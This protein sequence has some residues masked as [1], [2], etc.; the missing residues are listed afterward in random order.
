MLMAVINLLA[1]ARRAPIMA[2]E[3]AN[4]NE[5]AAQFIAARI[6]PLPKETSI[7]LFLDKRDDTAEWFRYRLSYLVYPHRLDVVRQ[8]ETPPNQDCVV[9]IGYRHGAEALPESVP[10]RYSQSVYT[11]RATCPLLNTALSV[12]TPLWKLWLY[13]ALAAGVLV[14]GSILIFYHNSFQKPFIASLRRVCNEPFPHL[15]PNL[16]LMHLYGSSL[17]LCAGLPNVA[18]VFKVGLYLLFLGLFTVVLS[19]RASQ[20]PAHFKETDESS[21]VGKS[22]VFLALLGVGVALWWGF[23][24]GLDWDGYAIW[25]L[26]AKAFFLDADLSMLRDAAH[27]DYAHRDYPLLF[28][29]HT[30]FLMLG[31]S[32]FQDG[33][34][35]FSTFL[36]YLDVLILFY[37]TAR[38]YVGSAKAWGGTALV[39]MLPL[40]IQ[41]A[42]SGFAD[43]PFA[44]YLLAT[45]IAVH[46][47]FPL[48]Q[49]GILLL[50]LLLT[51]NEGNLA[52]VVLFALCLMQ[53]WQ[54]T[55]SHKKTLLSALA[56]LAIL[57]IGSGSWYWIKAQWGLQNDIV[58]GVNSGEAVAR[59]PIVLGAWI[60]ALLKVGP[61][62]PCW[63]LFGVLVL[64]ALRRRS[65]VGVLWLTAGFQVMGYTLIYFITPHDIHWHIQTSM[66]RLLLHVAPLLLL[67]CTVNL[68]EKPQAKEALFP[69]E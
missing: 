34:A 32:T 46:F 62:F 24:L 31:Q 29:R 9:W 12:P 64:W 41:H 11:L 67:A 55:K 65:R 66:D 69:A 10:L 40:G 43:T 49:I 8:G 53:V 54:A 16:A 61:R 39:A 44:A 30:L 21:W 57:G 51:K 27:F 35:Q 33:I 13:P 23:F 15:L 14:V 17:L 1:M 42:T 52:V 28:S 22:G 18:G 58:N 4:E 36:F 63:G 45:A 38:L 3:N 5:Q 68:W 59:I 25:Q 7:A 20:I 2:R 48:G 60:E 47:R 19:P 6:A 37:Y 50:G 26:K 56:L